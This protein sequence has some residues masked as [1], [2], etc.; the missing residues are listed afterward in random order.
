MAWNSDTC[1]TWITGWKN[2]ISQNIRK[3]NFLNF[4]KGKFFIAKLKIW[5]KYNREE[6]GDMYYALSLG[7]DHDHHSM[8]YRVDEVAYSMNLDGNHNLKRLKMK[9]NRGF[10]SPNMMD[11]SKCFVIS[12]YLPPILPAGFA[13]T[14]YAKLVS[15]V[16]NFGNNLVDSTCKEQFWAASANKIMTDVQFIVGKESFYAHRSI[17]SARSPV[18][19]AMFTSGMKE[20]LTGQVLIDDVEP[21]TFRHFMEFV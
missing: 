11:P 6:N 13:I 20:C 3:N 7:Y 18:F 8:N 17:L 5:E 15:T 9:A 4:K 16:R 14:F 1:G 10:R 2:G 12:G 21:S 19:A